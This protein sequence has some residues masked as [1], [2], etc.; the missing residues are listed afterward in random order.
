M[1]KVVDRA[2]GPEGT[3]MTFNT[4]LLDRLD[5]Q[6]ATVF[7]PTRKD[8]WVVTKDDREEA[9]EYPVLGVFETAEQGRDAAEVDAQVD[10]GWEADFEWQGSD[11]EDGGDFETVL[12][13]EQVLHLTYHVT[14]HPVRTR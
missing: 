9:S 13:G 3:E 12:S 14:R 1:L 5:A 6:S 2:S 11:T 8:V 10:Y 7:G 4:S